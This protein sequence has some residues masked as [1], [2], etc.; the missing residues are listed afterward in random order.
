MSLLLALPGDWA[1]KTEAPL[2]KCLRENFFTKKKKKKRR[3]CGGYMQEK[4]APRQQMP[5]R[6]RSHRRKSTLGPTS[7]ATAVHQRHRSDRG[8]SLPGPLQH[9]PEK[10]TQKCQE[11]L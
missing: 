2:Q 1:G 9:H 11:V 5:L 8:L 4:E 7:K 10:E 3:G 6:A